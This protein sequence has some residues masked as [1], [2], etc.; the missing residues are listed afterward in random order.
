MQFATAVANAFA[1]SGASGSTSAATALIRSA[2]AFAALG[3]I[4]T[5]AG[6]TTPN[7]VAST[8]APLSA[9]AGT[10]LTQVAFGLTSS[11]AAASWQVVGA[12]PPGVIAQGAT[13]G[14]L[15]G[16]QLTGAGSVNAAN[17][18]LLGTPT[19]AGSYTVD[20]V[21]YESPNDQ[22]LST[23]DFSYAI[24]VA[25][26]AAAPPVTIVTA[27]SP[28]TVA[29]NTTIVFNVAATSTAALS[30]QWS[31]NGASISGATSPRLVVTSPSAAGTST[32]SVL[33]SNAAGG[34]ATASAAL[35]VAATASPGRL[36]NE[37]VLAPVTTGGN[38]TVGFS[39]TNGSP[40]LLIRG[41]GPTLGILGVSNVMPDP[42][43]QLI[44]Q[45]SSAPAATDDNWGSDAATTNLA[46]SATG[47]FALAAGSLDA[48]LVIT[49]TSTANSVILSPNTGGGMALAEIYDDSAT[50]YTPA[51]P[52]IVNL[53]T[54]FQLTAGS[55]LSAGFIV[56]GNTAKTF[57]IRAAGP[58]LSQAPFNLKGT[59]ADPQLTLVA[60]GSGAAIAA[61]QGWGGDPQIAAAASQV[62]AF[63]FPT[64]AL[65]D[66]ALLVTLSPGNY[67]ATAASASG[68][69]GQVLIEVYEVP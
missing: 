46:D 44:P 50:A 41:V 63:A 40:R 17:L 27:P 6:A 47:A 26:G 37:S 60:Q 30:Y 1:G 59:M 62:F 31:V 13:N 34:S 24:S 9:K 4:D 61:N 19:V 54:L 12:L 10:P 29:P 11:L 49:P 42:A 21:A 67:T 52:R 18:V 5:L 28:Q 55:T 57:L 8:P 51:S 68:G 48:A 25:A 43:I 7:V 15:S 32:Y 58:A 65:A 14:Q 39:T 38:L 64:P 69:G 33:V 53:S 20:I 2:S 16:P 66:S 22:D 56:G 45:G 23:A 3:A 36:I 35:Q